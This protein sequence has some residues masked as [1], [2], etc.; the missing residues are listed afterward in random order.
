[1]YL[2]LIY[3]FTHFNFTDFILSVLKDVGFYQAGKTQQK[4]LFTLLNPYGKYTVLTIVLSRIFM[5]IPVIPL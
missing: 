3:W 4:M 1:M 2:Y 5:E